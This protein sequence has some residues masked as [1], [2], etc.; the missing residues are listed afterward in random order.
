MSYYVTIAGHGRGAHPVGSPSKP[1][2]PGC[3]ARPPP[4]VP[5]LC[6]RDAS[7]VSFLRGQGGQAP[8]R[9][10]RGERLPKRGHF[11]TLIRIT[12]STARGDRGAGE[13]GPG[14]LTRQPCL[15][16]IPPPSMTLLANR[17]AWPT[18][19]NV[20]WPF[21]TWKGGSYEFAQQS[22]VYTYR[23]NCVT[24]MLTPAAT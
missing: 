13:G 24:I 15:A 2:G 7:W 9:P 21:P 20:S 8:G 12:R 22:Q 19:L 23:P 17:P 5:C 18:I 16:A 1:L 11:G 6:R 4:L 3:P 10:D 14:K